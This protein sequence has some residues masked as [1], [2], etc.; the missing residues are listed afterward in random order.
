[1][2]NTSFSKNMQN[3]FQSIK[4][5]F[6][7]K[8][9]VFSEIDSTNN[10]SKKIIQDEFDE[11]TIVIAET[12]K[13]GKGR[14]TRTWESPKGGLYCSLILKPSVPQQKITLLP[15]LASISVTKTLQKYS[16]KPTVKWPND[17]RIENKKI[18]GILIESSYNYEHILCVIL[19][20]GINLN[21]NLEQ[22]P[23]HLIDATT[24]VKIELNEPI[25]YPDFFKNL[26]MNFQN[27][28][29]VFSKGE[30]K[31]ILSVWKQQS[32]TLGKKVKI[33][34]MHGKIMGE[35]VNIDDSGFLQVYTDNNK[36]IT[37]TEGDCLYIR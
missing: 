1:M 25:N 5:N 36:I 18:A 32:D 30:F 13:K 24:S 4:N 11:V 31:E 29:T 7:K 19:G 16:L 21:I 35:A 12:Q 37:I 15:L 9:F 27:Y 6:Y 20:F 33:E 10:A 26:L 23:N 34:T 17:V 22:F 2:N 8:L 28:Y 14:L 3:A